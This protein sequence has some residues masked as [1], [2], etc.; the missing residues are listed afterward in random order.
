M[1]W[2]LF[3]SFMKLFSENFRLYNE[4]RFFLCLTQNRTEK[5]KAIEDE[6]QD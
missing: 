3:L 6:L 4:Y 1:G 5:E 2:K